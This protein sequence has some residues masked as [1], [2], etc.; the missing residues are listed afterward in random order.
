MAAYG[1]EHYEL[2][3]R[4]LKEE[5]GLEGYVVSDWGAVHDR[6]ACTQGRAGP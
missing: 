3:T 6:V 5:W 4:I 1:S 2:L